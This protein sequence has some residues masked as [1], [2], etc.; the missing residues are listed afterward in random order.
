MHTSVFLGVRETKPERGVKGTSKGNEPYVAT[1]PRERREEKA[2]V[3]QTHNPKTHARAF[4]KSPKC[5]WTLQH[6]PA[7]PE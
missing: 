5:L 1:R 4:A 3:S 2:P 6:A 7:L